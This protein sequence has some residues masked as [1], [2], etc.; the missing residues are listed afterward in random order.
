MRIY[1]KCGNIIIYGDE[2]K[3]GFLGLDWVPSATSEA[4]AQRYEEWVVYELN[5]ILS[6]WS[7]WCVLSE[8]FSMNR[9]GRKMSIKPYSP[10][11]DDPLNAYAAPLDPQAATLKGAPQKF[12]GG[13]QAGK[14]IPGAP[15][16]TGKGSD[17][18][19]R[20]TP[21]LF[22]PGIGGPGTNDPDEILL[23]EIVH[24]LREMSGLYFPGTKTQRFDTSEEFVA[25]L[26]SNIYRSETGRPGLRADHS[27]N[28]MLSPALSDPAAFANTFHTDLSLMQQ[29]D[30][31]LFF[32][33]RGLSTIPFNPTVHF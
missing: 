18:E 28:S 23:H 17:V 8:V 13:P 24:G 10:T 27:F 7:G 3:K 20:Y 33:L 2:Y 14:D 4:N 19:I 25:I 30:Q 29:E 12:G 31:N 6:R 9:N 1:N 5:L 21:W 11:P 32:K 15:P 26:V 22:R 16:G